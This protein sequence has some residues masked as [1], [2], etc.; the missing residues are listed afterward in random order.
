MKNLRL[1]KTDLEG[2]EPRD[3]CKAIRD[4]LQS[5]VCVGDEG[6]VVR[7]EEVLDQPSLSCVLVWAWR[8]RRLKRLLYR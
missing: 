4:V 3:V 6:S 8:R 7:E 2:R 5:L 1:L